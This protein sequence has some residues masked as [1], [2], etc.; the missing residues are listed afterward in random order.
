MTAQPHDPV[1]GH[2]VPTPKRPCSFDG[3]TRSA[4]C[5]GLC[6][7]HYEQQRLGRGLKPICARQLKPGV[8][9]G[10]LTVVRYCGSK[11]YEC[12]CSCGNT[13]TVEGGKLTRGDTKSCGCYQ[14]ERASKLT[15][16]HG[17]YRG[18][19]G[20]PTYRSWHSMRQRCLNPEAPNYVYYGERGVTVCERWKGRDGFPHFLADMGER[21]PGTT[22]DR[23]DNDGNYEPGN[24][25]WATPREQARNRRPARTI[26]S[27]HH[28][29]SHAR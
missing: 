8:V 2:Y 3:C 14:A 19:R 13:T 7:T 24:C 22:L 6:D 5:R 17:H 25:R 18:G 10:R 11:R 23:I 15:A 9:F 29:A 4:S 27:R 28:T 26:G 1:T 20:T 21:P 16:T 12:L